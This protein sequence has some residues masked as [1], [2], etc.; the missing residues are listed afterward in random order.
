MELDVDIV[1][2]E[3][4]VPPA[5]RVKLAGLR[6]IAGP[7]GETVAVSATVP[8]KPFRLARDMVEVVDEPAVTIRLVGLALTEKS[9]VV[10]PDCIASPIEIHPS[11]TVS[12][13]I[14]GKLVAEPLMFSYS[15]AITAPGFE[16]IDVNPGPGV[17]AQQTFPCIAAP[18][19]IS[20]EL[21]VETGTRV[22]A[23]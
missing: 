6:E 10:D 17:R 1:K 7:E 20:F 22:L 13:K 15:A 18:I 4:P 19:I 8:E 14:T 2:I 12:S 16:I 21:L 3:D 5:V 11:T 9:G 23:L